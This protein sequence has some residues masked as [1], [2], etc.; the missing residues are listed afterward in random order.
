[1]DTYELTVE[2]D[3]VRSEERAVGDRVL[4]EFEADDMRLYTF[5]FVRAN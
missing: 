1:V 2:L 4:A 5:I 3:F